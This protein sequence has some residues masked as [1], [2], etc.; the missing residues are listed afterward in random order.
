MEELAEG[1]AERYSVMDVTAVEESVRQLVAL[2]LADDAAGDESCELSASERARYDRQLAYFGDL[3]QPG[4]ARAAYQAEL[5]TAR[6]VVLGLGGVGSWIAWMLACVGVR[7]LDGVDHDA[8]EPTNLNRQ[9]L[10]TPAD[11]GRPKAEVAAEAIGR[12]N[13]DI[14]FVP[15]IAKIST[16]DQIAPL[17]E[18]ADL[19]VGA[20]DWPMHV[21]EG[22]LN[23]ACFKT[24]VPYI[25]AS[26]HSPRVRV[27]P[28]YIPRET[29]CL[30]CQEQIARSTNPH[31]D[32]LIEARKVQAAAAGSFGPACAILGGLAASE[33]VNYLTGISRPASAGAIL[34]LDL[35]SGECTRRPFAQLPDCAVCGSGG[36][37]ESPRTTRLRSYAQTASGVGATGPS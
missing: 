22:W 6:V 18:G 24:G 5:G 25:V 10:Y 1:L 12:F 15:H 26:Q 37:A 14:Q 20:V 31:F 9:V 19:V 7:K 3:A 16:P 21:I 36:Q 29:G 27:G 17:I 28:L 13:P 33:I 35:R 4:V 34:E 23:D 32:E 2:G 30:R 8:V 11:V